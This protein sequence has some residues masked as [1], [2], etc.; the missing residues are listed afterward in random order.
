[1]AA[2]GDPNIA[3]LY[4]WWELGPD[5][6]FV[7]EVPPPACEYWNLQ[8]NNHWMESLDYRWHRI[9]LNHHEAVLE[10]DGSVRIVV[11]HEDPGVPNW[12]ETAGHRRGNVCLRWV[13]AKE[14]PVPAVRV[15]KRAGLHA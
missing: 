8:V 2:H 13:G 4:S 3:Y 7:I 11:A 1:A 6:A 5:E 15:V 9:A 14:H 10:A 12:L